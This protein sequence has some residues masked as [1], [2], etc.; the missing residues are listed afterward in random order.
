M[1]RFVLA[2]IGPLLAGFFGKEGIR[3]LSV[4]FVLVRSFADLS[5]L[6]KQFTSPISLV[7]FNSPSERQISRVVSRDF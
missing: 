4:I 7:Q 1:G 2:S 5:Q 3:V 6:H